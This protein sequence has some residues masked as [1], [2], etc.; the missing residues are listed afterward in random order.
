M[1]KLK[2]I[3]VPTDFSKGAEVSYSVAQSIA[4]T[5]GG[6]IDFIHVIPT[7]TYLNES[8]KKLGVPLDMN[9]DIYPKIIDESELKLKKAMDQYLKDINKGSYKVKI[10]RRPA[11]AIVEY[12]SKND[13]DLILMGARGK[14]ESKFIRGSTTER[15]IRKSRV[16]VFSVDSRFDKN[17][18]K[19]IMMTT[20]TSELSLSAFPLTVSLA[21]AFGADITLFHV[22]ELYGSISEEIP[23]NPAKGEAVS[24]Y[25]GL[26][27]RVNRYLDKR[28]IENM[29]VVRTG[30]T[31]EDEVTITDGENSRSVQLFTKIEKGVSAHY[32]IE[33][34]ASEHADIVIMATHGHS[35][36]AH[37]ILGSTAEKV[38]QYVKKPVIT[39]RPEEEEF[40]VK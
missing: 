1:I 26:I 33:E 24:I 40:E 18:V 10:D 32:E 34:Y 5:F 31:F 23:R 13:Y 27:E 29:H 36:F 28:K 9:K 38:A 30:V 37:L 8:I 21:D 6:V 14:D 16:P 25:E 7:L 2:K 11:E 17:K 4:D 20:D 12:A 15:V 22:I 39:I 19:N 35:G 3:L